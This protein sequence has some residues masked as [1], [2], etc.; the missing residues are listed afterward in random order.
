MKW[1]DKLQRKFGRYAV[2]DLMKYLTMVYGAGLLIEIIAPGFYAQYLCLNMQ[3]VLHGQ[4][5]RLVTFMVYPPGGGLVMSLLIMLIYYHFGT[6][7][8]RCWGT[9]RFNL[10]V[11]SGI[12]FHIVAAVVVTLLEGNCVLYGA[13]YLH[14]TMM[15]AFITEFPDTMFYVMYF[16]PVKAKWIGIVDA[17]YLGALIVFGLLSPLIPT[18]RISN[19]TTGVVVLL[20]VLNYIIYFFSAPGSHYTPR[21]I[22]RRVEFARKVKVPMAKAGHHRCAVCGRTE[23]DGDELEFRFCSKCNGNFEYCQDHLYTHKHVE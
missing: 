6:T 1:I 4:I 17:I 15:L 21:Q 3:A 18:I 23:A 2:R 7:L 12:L 5:W 19:F 20:C 9:F 16:L 22:K 11:F 14:M 8:E 13:N 10:Y